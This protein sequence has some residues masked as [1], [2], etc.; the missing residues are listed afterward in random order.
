[1]TVRFSIII[2]VYNERPTAGVLIDRVLKIPLE[3]I[4]KEIIIVEGASTDGTCELIRSYE[5]RP[6]VHVIYEDAPRGK[7]A[8]VRR[9]LARA[10]GEILLIQD[11]DLEYDVVDYPRLLAP[12]LERRC[13]VVFGSRALDQAQRWQYRRFKGRWDRFYGLLVNWGGLFY[14]ILFNLLY[15]TRLTDGAT[16]FKL[17]RTEHLKKMVL[18]S[19]G[20]DYDWEIAA[21]LA[22]QG[23][24][25]L[26]VQIAYK[27]RTRAEGKK[28]RFWR[29]GTRV[30]LA[31]LRYRFA[32]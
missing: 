5:G 11:G 4:E 10:T 31:I 6:G 3:G 1:M 27:A 18:R 19:N 24:R 13:D 28:I 2:P 16:M 25:F 17:F 22:K 20:F 7:G 23:C 12:L 9:G 14:T 32:D 15:G 8:A 29:D 26:E 21:K 30:L